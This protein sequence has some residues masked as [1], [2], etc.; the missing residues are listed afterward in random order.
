MVDMEKLFSLPGDE[1]VNIPYRRKKK[2][3]LNQKAVKQARSEEKKKKSVEKAYTKDKPREST[4]IVSDLGKQ[5][6]MDYAKQSAGS[7][8][9]LGTVGGAGLAAGLAGLGSTTGLAA[10]SPY[11]AGA[12]LGLMAL[13]AYGKRK[14]AQAQAEYEAKVDRIQR[15]QNAIQ[16]LMNALRSGAMV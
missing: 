6:G 16:N 5:I 3:T 4:K 7:G 12:G 9:M 1:D 14:D 10:A 15:R 8:D 13:G 11:V 2:T